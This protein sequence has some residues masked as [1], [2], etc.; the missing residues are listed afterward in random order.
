MEAKK[1]ATSLMSPTAGGQKPS[2]MNINTP[3]V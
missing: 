3:N 2:T 1:A